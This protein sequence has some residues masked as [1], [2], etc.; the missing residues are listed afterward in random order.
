MP[1]AM[2]NRKIVAARFSTRAHRLL[3]GWRESAETVDDPGAGDGDVPVT[4]SGTG[5]AGGGVAG[6]AAYDRGEGRG[7]GGPVERSRDDRHVGGS[8]VLRVGE[9][10]PAA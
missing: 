1:E 2:E 8:L 4:P 9:G 5:E 7:V 6:L 3:D 10:R